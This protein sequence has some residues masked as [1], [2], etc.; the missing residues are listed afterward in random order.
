[1][2]Y[3]ISPN[4]CY[5]QEIVNKAT[6][7]KPISLQWRSVFIKNNYGFDFD[8]W[9]LMPLSIIFQLYHGDQF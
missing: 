5:R 8:F 7:E 9:C 4:L 6:L 1:M 3:K 2:F